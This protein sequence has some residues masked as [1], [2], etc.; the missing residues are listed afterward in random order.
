MVHNRYR[1]ILFVTGVFFV[2]PLWVGLPQSITQYD[3][4]AQNDL[5]S[6]EVQRTITAGA[7]LESLPI[8]DCSVEYI[9]RLEGKE[10][11]YRR[12][13]ISMEQLGMKGTP[14]RSSG[15]RPVSAAEITNRST[16]AG[17]LLVDLPRAG[18]SS[19]FIPPS[20][21]RYRYMIRAAVIP[22][23][24]EGKKLTAR[25]VIERA[26]VIEYERMIDVLQSEVFAREI[27]LI[28]NE[29]LYFK[30]PAWEGT[31]SSTVV[32]T[33]LEEALLITLESPRTFSFARNVP[34][35]FS[36]TTQ[37]YYAVPDRSTIRLTILVN[38]T[39]HVL[40]EGERDAGI[41]AVT[42]DA[43]LLRDGPF[44]ATLHA[45]DGRG[46]GLY[47]GDL[48]LTKDRN[49]RA[50]EP[51]RRTTTR[52]L[53]ERYLITTESG[54]AVQ[55]PKDVKRP[56]RHMFTHVAVRLGYTFSEYIEAGFLAGQD[57]FHE[58]PAENVDIDRIADYGGVVP[59][60]YGYIG[61]YLRW[62]VSTTTVR[63]LLQTSLA[64]S[65]A[66][67]LAEIGVGARATVFSHF[68]FILLP[69]V[70]MHFTDKTSTKV[71]LNYSIAVRF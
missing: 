7:S 62:T 24:L 28:G 59:Y 57:A 50:F 40:D 47:T 27:T 12:G 67:T 9:R 48:E 71:G 8:L 69:H 13:P 3:I 51:S 60:T 15:A 63:P 44:L 38:E 55:F 31:H 17:G 18:E 23:S 33:S 6:R 19:D 11:V 37:L 52:F 36:T 26:S 4:H 43:A 45:T 20:D 41:Y 54:F 29:P 32:P 34:E 49:A 5:F 2:L 25:I 22:T 21:K 1:E 58:E 53:T 46:K 39:E 30:L 56:L 70:T 10:I 66:A 42:W 14:D 61:A 64:F 68:D 65:D 35:P 16:F